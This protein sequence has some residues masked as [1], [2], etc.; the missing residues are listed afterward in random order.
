MLIPSTPT[1]TLTLALT[2]TLTHPQ[3]Q[4]QIHAA[5]TGLYRYL[6]GS[7]TLQMVH[8]HMHSS[9]SVRPDLGQPHTY[10]HTYTYHLSQPHTYIHTRITWASLIHTYRCA[11]VRPT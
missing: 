11:P 4:P 5:Y 1:L 7:Y 6:G 2:L 8:W 9:L 10:I 3:P